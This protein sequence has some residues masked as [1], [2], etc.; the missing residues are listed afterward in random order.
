MKKIII[1]G[2]GSHSVVIY[3]ELKKIKNIQISGFLK[4]NK[5]IHNKL[6]IKCFG[7]IEQTS[8]KVIKDYHFITAIGDNNLRRKVVKKLEKKFKKINWFSFCAKN[9]VLSEKVKLGKG[10]VILP[11][12][13]IGV[14]VKIKNHC[15]INSSCSID[16]DNIL[17]DFSSCG[18]GVITG[19]NVC[20]KES[21]FVGLG[22]TVKNNV[23]VAKDSFIGG[24]SFVNKNT[25]NKKLYFGVPI[26][27]IKNI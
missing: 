12:C 2:N 21:S 3:N 20:F 17:E 15:I 7:E 24:H 18:P 5:N 4:I 27:I 19:G 16:H 1:V 6:N 23:T 26:K 25:K 13:F 10:S 9:T 22:S 11:N 8:I 14:N